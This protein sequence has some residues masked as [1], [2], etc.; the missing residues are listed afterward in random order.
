MRI[1]K[2]Y[3]FYEKDEIE[4]LANE[5]LKRMQENPKY[6]PTYPLDASRVADFLQL[7]VVWEK[8]DEDDEELIAARIFPLKRLIEIN[9]D[10]LKLPNGFEASTIAHE[11]G[12]WILHI[13]T[14]GVDKLLERQETGIQFNLQ[15]FLC[16][17]T[18]NQKETRSI[19]WQAQYFASCLLMPRHILKEKR[20]GRDLTNWHDL[21]IM[22]DELGV[23]ISNLTHR[24]KELGWIHIIPNTGQILLGEAVPSHNK[25]LLY[26]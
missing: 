11:I 9:E 16:R 13:D 18:N 2:P 20:L 26:S 7:A 6:T 10:I 22:K 15:P 1:F 8:I 23:T 19:E 25:G 21:Y 4:R 12:H 14:D 24:L 5:L 17:S 3:R